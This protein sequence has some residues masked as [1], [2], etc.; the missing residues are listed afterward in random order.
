MDRGKKVLKDIRGFLG[1][2]AMGLCNVYKRHS[3]PEL[4]IEL[5][6]LKYVL[7]HELFHSVQDEVGSIDK[8]PHWMLEGEASL[9]AVDN[10]EDTDL[11]ATNKF[12]VCR[13]WTLDYVK[14][15]RKRLITIFK[16][17]LRH[18]Y[19]YFTSLPMSFQSLD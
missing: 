2:Y 18:V 7:K 15:W 14:R 10:F 12:F 5:D 4:E 16:K 6:T 3:L 17:K 1:R 9:A 13:D 19:E 11:G 8:E